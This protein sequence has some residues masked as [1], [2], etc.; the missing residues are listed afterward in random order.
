MAKSKKS[1]ARG[2]DYYMGRVRAADPNL[3]EQWKRNEISANEAIYQAGLKRRPTPLDALKRNWRNA[4][5][6]ER[7][8][9]LHEIGAVVG[10]P[11]LGP[12]G[13]PHTAPKTLKT[14]RASWRTDS[15]GRLTEGTVTRLRACM[16]ALGLSN[17][18]LM[19]ELGFNIHD[20][21][22]AGVLERRT[23]VPTDL[24]GPLQA[25]L[26]RAI[27]RVNSMLKS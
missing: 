19:A 11:L 17:A 9:F 24:E 22:I 10:A 26:A 14:G 13:T 3:Y 6:K 27:R 25:W 1:A 8:Q 20:W 12:S 2:A 15:A 21:R 23:A 7:D 16:G 5:E 18:G 4:N